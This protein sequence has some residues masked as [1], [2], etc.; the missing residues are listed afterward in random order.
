MSEREPE[1]AADR[2][3]DMDGEELV[4]GTGGGTE[5]VSHVTRET[6]GTGRGSSYGS[7]MRSEA[8]EDPHPRPLRRSGRGFAWAT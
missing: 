5:N 3:P 7:V 1:R 2:G 8:E 6:P 4:D